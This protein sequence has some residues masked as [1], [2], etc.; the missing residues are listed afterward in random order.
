MKKL[1]LVL[2]F[3]ISLF[4]SDCNNK[5]FNYA[6][7]INPSERLSIK[8]FLNLLVTQQCGINIVYKD[9]KAKIELNKKMPFVRIKNYTLPQILDLVLAK[10]GLFY[11]LK[12]NELDV[13]YYKTKTYKLD[14][15]STSREGEAQLNATDNT[16]KNTYKF[17][18]WD[19]L[20]NKITL[21]L[22]NN[23]DTS[24]TLAS[25][26]GDKGAKNTNKV[27]EGY[28]EP[29]VDKD[30]GIIVVTGTMKQIKAVDNFMKNLY[31]ALTKE[32]L[33]DV[34]IYSVELSSSHKTGID[35]SKLQ[36]ALPDSTVPLRSKYIAGSAS[37]FNSATFSAS[38]LLNFLAQNGNVN[39][40]SNPK[41][42]TLNNQKAI[43][44]VGDTIYYKY[45]SKVVTDQNG[46]PSTEYTINSK[47]VGV[48]LDITPQISDNGEIILSIAPRISA[49]RDPTQ[50]NNTNR[51]M[52]PDT[53]DSTMLS[54]VKMK[55]DQTLVLGGLI[56]ND[57][58]L[59]VNGVPILKEIPLVKYL[60]SSR[61]QITTKK[62]LVFV[63]TPHIIDL[64]K[65][66]T[67]RDL[68]FEQVRGR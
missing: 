23:S 26:I 51:G 13:S 1:V 33:I 32:V 6:N 52:P 60:F 31:K 15:I 65:K 61:E 45:A 29:I 39:S 9:R 47:F 38:A 58:T 59:K 19:K 40:I 25:V 21:I 35:W 20:K 57:K 54:I 5:L 7:S 62:E 3:A 55:D 22:K 42:V 67:L 50:L 30:S 49:F 66:K 53:K 64:K 46:N 4:A 36:I 27:N 37:L 68:G 8:E 48:V 2:F 11:T 16:I 56:T 41:I 12:D 14:F 63:I 24:I 18:F 10:R 43:I 34:R 28:F 44:S 17:D